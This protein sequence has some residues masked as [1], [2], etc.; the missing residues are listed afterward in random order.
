MAENTG[1]PGRRGRRPPGHRPWEQQPGELAQ[2]FAQF[3]VYL[4]LGPS[5][6]LAKAS[7]ECGLSLSR[8]KWLSV[9]WNWL[10][11]AL[12]WDRE[13][14]LRRRREELQ[15]CQETRERLLKESADL[16][17]IAGMEFRSW[18]RRD[19]QGELQ[20]VR[21]LS[22]SEAI[23]LWQVGCE[24]LQELQGDAVASAY[25][26]GRPERD[27]FGQY[28]VQVAVRQAAEA[29]ARCIC[30]EHR[31]EVTEALHDVII[32]W[33]HYYWARHPDPDSLDLSDSVWPWDMPYAEA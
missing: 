10:Y 2:E 3:R 23:R 13:Q 18:V 24:A 1:R 4:S 17:R 11:R 30:Y 28:P 7:Q 29:A 16:Q 31:P 15:A 6:S 19:E 22:P 9:R 33:V 25:G 27:I 21:E 12:A 14:F 20:L 32:A 26:Q 8:L 5:R